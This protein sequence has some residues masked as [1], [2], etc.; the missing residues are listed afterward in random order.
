VFVEHE[1]WL[2]C[3]QRLVG[4]RLLELRQQF[5]RRRRQFAGG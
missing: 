5:V 2:R 4:Q 3:G 1:W